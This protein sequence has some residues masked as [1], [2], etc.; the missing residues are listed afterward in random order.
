MSA[1]EIEIL[2]REINEIANKQFEM[3]DLIM[4]YHTEAKEMFNDTNSKMDAIIERLEKKLD[5]ATTDIKPLVELTKNATGAGRLLNWLFAQWKWFA[6][7]AAILYFYIKE[8][9]R[10]I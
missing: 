10:K 6:L 7:L 2:R 4:N 9:L 3:R 1:E 5:E 8:T